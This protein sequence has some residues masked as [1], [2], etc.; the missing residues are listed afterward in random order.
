MRKHQI[1]PKHL[2]LS[3]V[4]EII[5]SNAKIELSQQAID[6]VQECRDYLDKKMQT[7]EVPVYGVTTGFGSLC[8]TTISLE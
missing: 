2:T 7:S 8:N 5:N 3:R 6:A 4:N 1:S